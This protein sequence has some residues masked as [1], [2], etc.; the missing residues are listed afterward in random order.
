MV[1]VRRLEW[2]WWWWCGC[3]THCTELNATK[4][5]NGLFLLP[6]LLS[7]SLTLVVHLSRFL[8]L[9]L[10]R[11]LLLYFPSLLFWSLLFYLH[12]CSYCRSL[13]SSCLVRYLLYCSITS[14]PIVVFPLS[15]HP[16]S[17]I[18]SRYYPSYYNLPSISEYSLFSLILFYLV[19]ISISFTIVISSLFYL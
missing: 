17:F 19:L 1:S 8:M 5:H 2:W 15:L 13:C 6:L 14:L 9:S 18:L 4:W 10:A 11:F 12:N 3:E 16:I 7:D